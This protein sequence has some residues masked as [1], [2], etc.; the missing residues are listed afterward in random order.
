MFCLSHP[1]CFNSFFGKNL[2]ETSRLSMA[3]GPSRKASLRQLGWMVLQKGDHFV[4]CLAP[5]GQVSE[6]L[7]EELLITSQIPGFFGWSQFRLLACKFLVKIWHILKTAL[8]Q[9]QLELTNIRP[10]R[11]YSQLSGQ[12][13]AEPSSWAGPPSWRSWRMPASLHLR[14]PSHSP[15]AFFQDF[16]A[17]A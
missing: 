16:S 1:C 4:L 13:V 10:A 11:R 14:R 5:V 12:R 3:H 9:T 15:Q 6:V 2:Q 8:Q 7:E 17:E